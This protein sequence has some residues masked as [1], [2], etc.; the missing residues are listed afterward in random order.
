MANT[1][2]KELT[3]KQRIWLQTYMDIEGEYFG[4]A[5]KSA[6]VA[7]FPEFPIKKALPDLTT[8]ERKTYNIAKQIGHENITKLDIPITELMDDAGLSDVYLLSVLAGNLKATRLYGKNGIEHGDYSS[9]NKAL[10]MALKIKKVLSDKPEFGVGFF[11]LDKMTIE[12]VDG[13]KDGDVVDDDISLP[14]GGSTD[15]SQAESQTRDNP[16]GS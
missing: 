12:I 5:T 11:A 9:R 2:K 8:E 7:Y 14:G 3:L 1:P 4:N 6:L 16:E 10:E 13:K 15:E